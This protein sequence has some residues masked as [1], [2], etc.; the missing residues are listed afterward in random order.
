[1]KLAAL[2]VVVANIV[3]YIFSIWLVGSLITSAVKVHSKQCG[4]SY[5]VEGYHIDG[6]FFCGK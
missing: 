3:G 1:M 5:G 4:T 2:L 6:N